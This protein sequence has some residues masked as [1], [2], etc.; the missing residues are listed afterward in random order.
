[1]VGQVPCSKQPWPKSNQIESMSSFQTYDVSVGGALGQ[2]VDNAGCPTPH[3]SG[4][5]KKH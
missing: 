1:M 4:L 2:L 3:C 5:Y